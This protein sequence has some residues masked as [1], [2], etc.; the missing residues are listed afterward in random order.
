MK[1]TN[2]LNIKNTTIH[3]GRKATPLIHWLRSMQGQFC[4]TQFLIR[5]LKLFREISSFIFTGTTSQI[6]G[7]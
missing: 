2:T 4:V 5:F 7:P 6:W 3:Q 1:L